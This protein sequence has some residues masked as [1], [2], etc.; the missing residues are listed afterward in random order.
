MDMYKNKRALIRGLLVILLAASLTSL[1]LFLREI[2]LLTNLEGFDSLKEDMV[3]IIGL[4]LANCVAA[5]A[6]FFFYTIHIFNKESNTDFLTGVYNK[7]KFEKTLEK[8]YKQENHFVLY[9]VDVDFFKHINDTYGHVF[10]DEVLRDLST[11][12]QKICKNGVFRIGGDEFAIIS[13]DL[14]THEKIIA[15]QSENLCIGKIRYT[16][17]FG[18]ENSRQCDRL[19]LVKAAD[20]NMYSNK[21]ESS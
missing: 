20:K 19:E 10:G 15:L 1:F 4:K 12:L 21:R 8:N 3:S 11:R 17:S 6:I 13:R 14:Q 7:R 18:C 5:F 2:E 9:I 16:F